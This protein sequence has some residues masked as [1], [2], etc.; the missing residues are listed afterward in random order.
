MPRVLVP[1]GVAG[2][3]GAFYAIVIERHWW[4]VR[5]LTVPCLPAGMPELR[6]L[7]LSDLHFRSGQ[8]LKRRFLQGLAEREWDLIVVTGDFLGDDVSNDSLLEALSPLDA[9]IAK[10]FVLGSNDYYGPRFKNPL[11]Y[12]GAKGHGKDPSGYKAAGPNPWREMVEGLQASGWTYLSNQMLELSSDGNPIEVAGLDDAHIG[13]AKPEIVPP[14][15][16]ERF[17]LGVVHSPDSIRDLVAR[18]FDLILAGHTHG[19]QVRVP[20]YGALVTNCDIPREWARGLHRSGRSAVH[21]SAGLGT[22]MFAPYR[23]SCRPEVSALTLV[24]RPTQG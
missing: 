24:G 21:V 13:R 22:S 16:D 15:S 11:K 8:G 23:F 5:D 12:F 10:L 7:H 14:R 20:G 9:S 19:G 6:V 2:A 4:A 1:I 17:R 3:L 18:D